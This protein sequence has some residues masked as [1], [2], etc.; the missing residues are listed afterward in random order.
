MDNNNNTEIFI[1]ATESSD[2]Q[3]VTIMLSEKEIYS[4][5]LQL[6]Y[7]SLDLWKERLSKNSPNH[8]SLIAEIKEEEKL[9]VVGHISISV[10]SAMRRKHVGYIGMGVKKEYH[11]RGIGAKLLESVLDMADNWLNL[12]RVELEVYTDN[13]GAIALYE[14]YGFKTEGKLEK[15]AFRNGKYD[16]VYKMA[17][18][19]D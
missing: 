7:P 18:I 13:K 4:N 9:V 15:Y 1:R 17:R 2:Y 10:F 8:F 5:M 6:P 16:D 12:I 19:R 3:E 14:K 11:R